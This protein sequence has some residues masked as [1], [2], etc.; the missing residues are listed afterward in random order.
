MHVKHRP[1]SKQLSFIDETIHS[2][3]GTNH[4]LS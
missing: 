4:L 1:V 3:G 2:E